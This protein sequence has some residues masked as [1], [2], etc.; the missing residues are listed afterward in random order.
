MTGAGARLIRRRTT[1]QIHAGVPAEE[2]VGVGAIV[3]PAAAAIS[4]IVVGSSWLIASADHDVDEVIDGRSLSASRWRCERDNR[5]TSFAADD[6]TARDGL[7]RRS[8]SGAPQMD[9]ERG[10]G[11]RRRRS[12]PRQAR[13]TLRAPEDFVRAQVAVNGS[14]RF[15]IACGD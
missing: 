4:A 11:A 14:G 5:V 8:L 2:K 10:E 3:A 15:A 6:L 9:R 13:C 1:A 12:R 7:S